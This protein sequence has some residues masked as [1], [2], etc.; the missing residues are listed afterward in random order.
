M[1][2]VFD[3][4][5]LIDY[6]VGVEA[7]RR[8]LTL[9]ARPLI[10]VITWIE[11]MV[12]AREGEEPRLRAFLNRFDQVPVDDRVAEIA[13]AIRRCYRIRI[14]DALIWAS[15]KASSALLVTRNTRD[16]PTEAPDV[17]VPYA[18]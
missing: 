4:N 12:G 3:T 14:P 1:K 11:V 7:A 17:R 10:S 16:F 6:L 9:Y 13:V 8:E 18:L 5:I 2:V 15:A